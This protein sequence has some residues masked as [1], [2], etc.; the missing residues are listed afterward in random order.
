MKNSESVLAGILAQVQ[1]LQSQRRDDPADPVEQLFNAPIPDSLWHYTTLN[2]LEGILRSGKIWATEAR[3]TTDQSEFVHAHD[4][5][6]S[7][8][9][10]LEPKTDSEKRAKQDGLRIVEEEFG[11]GALSEKATEVFVASFS[12][13]EN[14]KSQWNEYSDKGNGVSIAFDLRQI[15][16]PKSLQ[17]AVTLAPAFTSRKTQKN[18][19]RWR[20]AIT[21]A[22]Q[23]NYFCFA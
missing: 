9:K 19:C 17:V 3:H 21:S 7:Y 2:G 11:T 14:L 20:S 8:L 18:Y 4:L 12:S 5:A 10:N 6:V 23:S 1:A 15:R 13:V 22:L 16:P